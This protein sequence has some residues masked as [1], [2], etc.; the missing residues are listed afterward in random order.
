MV[1]A[2]SQYGHLE[3]VKWLVENGCEFQTDTM[4]RAAL[5]GSV[6]LCRWLLRNGCKISE[7]TVPKSIPLLKLLLEWG[8]K[9][10]P[11][12]FSQAALN[13]SF[14]LMKWAKCRGFK[15]DESTCASAAAAGRL[16]I[17]EW[18]RKL[19]CPWNE[20]CCI[21]AAKAGDLSILSW[22][23]ERRCPWTS[24][25][26][27]EA[28]MYGHFKV[29]K[30]AVENGCPLPQSIQFSTPVKDIAN[31]EYLFNKGFKVSSNGCIEAV[32]RGHKEALMWFIDHGAPRNDAPCNEAANQGRVAL[33]LK[34]ISKQFPTSEKTITMAVKY[35]FLFKWL[36]TT[37]KCPWDKETFTEIVK[38]QNLKLV[39]WTIKRNIPVDEKIC[40]VAA[41]LGNIEVMEMLLH[42][43]CA[44]TPSVCEIAIKK[45]HYRLLYWLVRKGHVKLTKE[46]YA[47]AKTHSSRVFQ[48]W[49]DY[50]KCPTQ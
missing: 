7:D 41:E 3:I 43:N 2:A 13:G 50:H 24:Q 32:R 10:G 21:A 8:Y 49:L 34:L 39:K 25:V 33:L 31:I 17:L 28:G 45:G 11:K 27:T 9:P 14:G 38:A 20:T 6:E 35:P 46:L 18:A 40:E 26:I 12:F 4:Y 1:S 19:E 15:W 23:R 47:V 29:M 30:W 44:L 48:D 42:F 22:A 5:S 37:N 16:D 36:K